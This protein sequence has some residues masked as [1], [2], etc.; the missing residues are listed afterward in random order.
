MELAPPEEQIFLVGE[1]EYVPLPDVLGGELH[2]LR[3]WVPGRRL[4]SVNVPVFALVLHVVREA[5][6]AEAVVLALLTR[7]R[8]HPAALVPSL[9]VQARLA[10]SEALASMPDLEA[11]EEG[12]HEARDVLPLLQDL[13]DVEPEVAASVGGHVGPLVIGGDERSIFQELWRYFTWAEGHLPNLVPVAC[14]CI[15]RLPVLM[16]VRLI[17]LELLRTLCL[18]LLAL[19]WH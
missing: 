19:C 13:L 4:P 5:R 18:H 12:I 14:F 11:R 1:V 8:L 15:V 2:V 7:A 17:T 6:V 16:E 10:V 3:G 9:E